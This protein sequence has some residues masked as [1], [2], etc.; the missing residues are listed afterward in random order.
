MYSFQKR[1][2]PIC[3]DTFR[4]IDKAIDHYVEVH[5]KRFACAGCPKRFKTQNSLVIHI[6]KE[7]DAD[8]S[9]LFV[10]GPR[11]KR[12]RAKPAVKKNQTRTKVLNK[13]EGHIK[14]GFCEY[15]VDKVMGFE[16]H[17]RWKHGTVK[18][19]NHSSVT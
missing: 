18:H 8:P 3:S 1:T 2:C 5:V 13:T 15:T 14:C 16:S 12:L 10:V 6:R 4:T 17:F 9:L 19:F 7:H 11:I